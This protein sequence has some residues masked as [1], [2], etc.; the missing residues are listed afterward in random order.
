MIGSLLTDPT[1]RDAVLLRMGQLGVQLA[2]MRAADVSKECEALAET[3]IA[4]P[5]RNFL[6]S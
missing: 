5:V 2:D 4:G 3:H 1:Q 6:Y